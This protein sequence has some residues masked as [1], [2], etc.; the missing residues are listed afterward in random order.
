MKHMNTLN[1]NTTELQEMNTAEMQETEGGVIPL[2]LAAAA[3]ILIND[4]RMPWN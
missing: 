1:F 4:H 3:Y 2:M